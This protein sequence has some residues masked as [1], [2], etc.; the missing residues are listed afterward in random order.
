M[1]ERDNKSP[2]KGWLL[3]MV[4]LIAKGVMGF[5]MLFYLLWKNTA[6]PLH[7][8][9]YAKWGFLVGLGQLTA[10]SSMVWFGITFLPIL[11]LWAIP[12][13]VLVGILTFS[14][15]FPLI[16]LGLLRPIYRSLRWALRQIRPLLRKVLKQIWRFCKWLYPHLNRFLDWLAPYAER[17]WNW[18]TGWLD[19]VWTWVTVRL[20]RV[21]NWFTGWLDR[22]W[23]WVTVR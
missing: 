12:T 6:S 22:V 15:G 20:R 10:L 13:A 7:K 18:F 11:S 9:T 21:W 5:F 19:R 1:N 17:F 3:T 14:H 23:T 16:Y 2:P 8:E 4:E